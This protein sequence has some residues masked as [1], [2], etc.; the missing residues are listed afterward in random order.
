MQVR[1]CFCVGLLESERLRYP[2]FVLRCYSIP[3]YTHNFEKSAFS[4]SQ[5]TKERRFNLVML[6]LP[7]LPIQKLFKQ[8]LSFLCRREPANKVET[9]LESTLQTP[10]NK[11]DPDSLEKLVYNRF[12]SLI[13]IKCKR[14]LISTDQYNFLFPMLAES[15]LN[16]MDILPLE[17]TDSQYSTTDSQNNKLK[18]VTVTNKQTLQAFN[19]VFTYS[20]TWLCDNKPINLPAQ[21]KY[22]NKL[23]MASYE[24]L[25]RQNTIEESDLLMT[26]LERLNLEVEGIDF[27]YE[28]LTVYLQEN[29]LQP[30]EE[31][32]PASNNAKRKIYET[33]LS[34]LNALANN[35]TL[36]KD[37]KQDDISI[38]SFS[39]NL[40]NRIEQLQNQIRIMPVDDN[41]ASNYFNLFM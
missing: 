27:P 16:D 29:G 31:Y 9:S 12:P 41:E 6:L 11:I 22:I 5:P 24:Q 38:S 25:Q 8:L 39:K 23:V 14:A 10:T 34:S 1:L 33:A 18:G 35:P 13:P 17:W 3:F 19:F 2:N 30:E 7:L 28:K 15:L 26:N 32:N 37:Y 21:Q 36:L 20:C 40:Q 4:S